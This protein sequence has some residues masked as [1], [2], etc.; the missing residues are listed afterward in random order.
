[1]AMGAIVYIKAD[2]CSNTNT[3]FH[4]FRPSN[5]HMFYGFLACLVCLFSIALSRTD[6]QMDTSVLSS[7]SSSLFSGSESESCTS[8]S[9]P[10]TWVTFE[11]EPS[12]SLGGSDSAPSFTTIFASLCS[13]RLQRCFASMLVA[14]KDSFW[15]NWSRL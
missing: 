13:Y 11:F 9:G 14:Y 8:I 10:V 1:M 3:I 6:D 5:L 4:C 2:N 12:S 15:L 7:S